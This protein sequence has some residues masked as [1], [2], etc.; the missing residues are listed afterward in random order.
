MLSFQCLASKISDITRQCTTVLAH[1]FSR[2]VSILTSVSLEH[3][4]MADA[5]S[6][7]ELPLS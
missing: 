3:C 7:K 5:N 2:I 4:S 6:N 1:L